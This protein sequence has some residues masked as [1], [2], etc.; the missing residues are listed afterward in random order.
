MRLNKR[1]QILL[2]QEDLMLYQSAAKICKLSAAEWARRNLR[3][4]AQQDLSGDANMDHASA[5]A[6]IVKLHA[7]VDD[8]DVMIKQSIRGRLS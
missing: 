6:A 7:P 2:S 1:L 5:A 3:K 8:L 4:A